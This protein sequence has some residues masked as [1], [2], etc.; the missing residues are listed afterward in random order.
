M[1]LKFHDP[2]KDERHQQQTID[3]GNMNKLMSGYMQERSK[4]MI[5]LVVD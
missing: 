4:H 2:V 1:S 5:G 3:M